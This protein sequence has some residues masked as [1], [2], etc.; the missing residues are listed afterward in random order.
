MSS[1]PRWVLNVFAYYP[2]NF[3]QQ[4]AGG[5]IKKGGVEPYAYM[6]LSQAAGKGAR[7]KRTHIGIVGKR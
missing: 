1:K 2:P 5:D 3:I 7:G 4:K 6:T